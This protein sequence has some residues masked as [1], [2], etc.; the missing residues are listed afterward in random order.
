MGARSQPCSTSPEARSTPVITL[1]DGEREVT[2]VCITQRRLERMNEPQ[3]RKKVA[4]MI[5]TCFQISVGSV[6]ASGVTRV[7]DASGQAASPPWM[8]R[9]GG[10]LLRTRARL[11]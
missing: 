9:G 10:S 5:K 8:A 3:A 11:S 4:A 6:P 1:Y 2:A 7:S